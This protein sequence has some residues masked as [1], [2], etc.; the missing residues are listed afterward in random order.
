MLRSFVH[1][2]LKTALVFVLLLSFG[3]VVSP[4]TLFA[5]SSSTQPLASNIFVEIAKK[6]NPAVVNVSTKA[7]AKRTHVGIFV[8]PG[9]VLGRTAIPFVIFMT[10][11]SGSVRTKDQE[12]VWVPG[13]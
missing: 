12:A 7:K 8:F 1:R 5:L 11:S 6:Q 3:L 2:A 4:G 13:S 10:A 9:P